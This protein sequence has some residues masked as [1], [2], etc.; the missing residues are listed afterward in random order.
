MAKGDLGP[1]VQ[2]MSG[3]VVNQVFVRKKT[4]KVIIRAMPAKVDNPNS[5]PQSDRRRWMGEFGHYWRHQLTRA[6]QVRWQTFAR[7]NYRKDFPAKMML[8]QGSADEI[9]GLNAFCQCNMLARDV[10]NTVLI[11]EPMDR[12]IPNGLPGLN[13]S[14]DGTKLTITWGNIA[15]LQENHFVRIWLWCT[16]QCFHRQFAAYAPGGDKTKD[17]TEVR[18]KRGKPSPL[19]S[20]K[21][22]MLLIQ[23]D[24]VDRLSGYASAPSETLYFKI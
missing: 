18:G 17:I 12:E 21:G 14:F 13:A 5:G 1:Y 3:R 19:S 4:G 22:T 23:A 15:N 10:G 8:I 11:R 7:A 24:V 16:D 9:G 6:E 2:S 20:K